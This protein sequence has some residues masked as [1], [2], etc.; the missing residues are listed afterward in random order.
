MTK[1]FHELTKEEKFEIYNKIIPW[2]KIAQKYPQPVWCL[3]E[4]AICG[5]FG[6]DELWEGLIESKK[7]CYSCKWCEGGEYYE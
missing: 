2:N 3:H 7:D 5:L 6:C 4:H 1:Y